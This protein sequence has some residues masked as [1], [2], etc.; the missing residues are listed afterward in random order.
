MATR[1]SI[2]H[3]RRGAT[4]LTSEAGKLIR[5]RALNAAHQA[6]RDG[7]ADGSRGRPQAPQ[8]PG[9]APQGGTDNTRK[10]RAQIHVRGKQSAAGRR[11]RDP[12]GQGLATRLSSRPLGPVSNP[13]RA[14]RCVFARVSLW[15]TLLYKAA[16]ARS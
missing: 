16:Y 9:A 12:P 13:K 11:A 2:S 3:I 1:P 7:V 6:L 10:R 8:R 15:G 5:D 4:A 14:R